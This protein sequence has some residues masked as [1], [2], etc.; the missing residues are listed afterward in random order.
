MTQ[1]QQ[2]S[3]RNED[4]CLPGFQLIIVDID[5]GVSV[6]TA[7]LLM[8]EYAYHLYTTKRHT[9]KQHRFRM[10]FPMSHTLKL[11]AA[12]YREFMNN[13]YDWLPFEV[14]RQT[15]QRARKWLCNPASD[16]RD[17]HPGIPIDVLPFIPKTRKSEEQ[18]KRTSEL[19]NMS[20]VERWFVA[21][22]DEG[23]RSNMMIRY[24]LMLVSNNLN[25]ADIREKVFM[26]NS[27]LD[28]GLDSDEIHATILTTANRAIYKR[29]TA[30]EATNE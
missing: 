17:T 11:D 1:L 28:P 30:Q 10:I 2:N 7:E 13:I 29:D 19:R 24:A 14:D 22:T 6:D 20:N 8:D 5:S 27:K 4:N 26:L 16:I 12:D 15:N 3:R 9:D 25:N 18:K 23:N 21:N